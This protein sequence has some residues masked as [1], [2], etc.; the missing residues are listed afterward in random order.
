MLAFILQA[1][2]FCP[3]LLTANNHP[4]SWISL[5]SLMASKEPRAGKSQWSLTQHSAKAKITYAELQPS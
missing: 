4:G 5:P 2:Y 3:I 1:G